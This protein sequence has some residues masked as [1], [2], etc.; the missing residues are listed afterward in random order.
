M[1]LGGRGRGGLGPSGLSSPVKSSLLTKPGQPSA[2]SPYKAPKGRPTGTDHGP[3]YPLS[4]PLESAAAA[5]A[6]AAG[7]AGLH[8]P[9]FTP[10]PYQ[11]PLHHLL[12]AAQQQAYPLMHQSRGGGT[13]AAAALEMNLE[14]LHR[15]L[16]FKQQAESH[17]VKRLQKR[18]VWHRVLSRSERS[19]LS[20]SFF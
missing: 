9:P 19:V 3:P 17:Q 6:M 10:P 20:R 11:H 15:F 4:P 12:W 14:H 8:L 16:Q 7:G 18:R 1:S 13:N 5:A 2:W